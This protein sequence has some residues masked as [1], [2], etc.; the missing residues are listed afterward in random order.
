[1]RPVG[2]HILLAIA[3]ASW[4]AFAI[5]EDAPDAPGPTRPEGAAE[6]STTPDA[7][8][9]TSGP[10][11]AAGAREAEALAAVLAPGNVQARVDAVVALGARA[12]DTAAVAALVDVLHT[13]PAPEVRAHAIHALAAI[14]PGNLAID[15]AQQ[16]DPDARVTGVA[17]LVEAQA[18]ANRADVSRQDGTSSVLIGITVG[19]LSYGISV[20][21]GLIS[22]LVELGDG[23]P[24]RES[25][26]WWYLAP[27]AGPFLAAPRSDDAGKFYVIAALDSL[28]QATG[29]AMLF[30]G[31][32]QHIRYGRE[33]RERSLIVA[34]TIRD[35]AT[36]LAVMGVF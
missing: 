3:L 10:G 4:P 17:G 22:G 15:E 31:L 21:A 18:A 25:V 2:S 33:T 27:I 8:Q 12:D 34:P 24:P 9:P 13:D 11:P 35:G 23:T 7:A 28:V 14:S 16:G 1:V 26:G 36:S 19:C 29:I 30:V 32:A 5:A 20:L 6:G